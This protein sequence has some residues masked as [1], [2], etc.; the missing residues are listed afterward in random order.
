MPFTV[1]L[2][3]RHGS[4]L[5][6]RE[7]NLLRNTVRRVREQHPFRI[8]AWVVLPEHLHCVMTLPPGDSDVGCNKRSALHRMFLFF[9]CGAMPVGY[10]ALR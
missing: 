10:C 1:N 6:V 3:Q 7:I 4:D 5:L 2:L 9:T 8:D